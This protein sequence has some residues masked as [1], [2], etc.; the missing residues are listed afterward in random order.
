M[1]RINQE[2]SLAARV[3]A[4]WKEVRARRNVA[5]NGIYNQPTQRS[6][7]G[8]IGGRVGQQL[9]VNRIAFSVAVVCGGGV[10]WVACR[11]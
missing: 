4:R 10:L 7:K 9:G 2:V 5:S 6:W 1:V 3:F 8:G 11:C